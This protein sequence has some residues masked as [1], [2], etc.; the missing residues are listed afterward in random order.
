MIF[1]EGHPTNWSWKYVQV[2]DVPEEEQESYEGHKQRLDI[3]NGLIFNKDDFM[4]ACKKMGITENLK[5][6]K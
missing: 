3:E 1:P 6:D 4:S 5:G 2:V